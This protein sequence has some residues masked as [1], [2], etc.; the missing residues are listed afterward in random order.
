MTCE[1]CNL[2]V[3]SSEGCLAIGAHHVADAHDLPEHDDGEETR[4]AYEPDGY[5]VDAQVNLGV[6]FELLV[7][8]SLSNSIED[9][10]LQ[11]ACRNERCTRVAIENFLEERRN[12][13]KPMNQ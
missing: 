1:A 7:L 13:E 10:R 4:P 5:Q 2:L 9:V 12:F 6:R 3:Y 11:E 8:R